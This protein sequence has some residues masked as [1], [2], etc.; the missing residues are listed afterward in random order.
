MQENQN[1]PLDGAD[2]EVEAALASLRPAAHG[3]DRDQ[4]IFTAGYRS[5][6]FK[7][8]LWRSAAGAL[9]AMVLLSIFI[10]PQL[11]ASP[12]SPGSGQLVVDTKS[13]APPPLT[14]E[15]VDNRVLEIIWA[16][17]NQPNQSP[18]SQNYLSL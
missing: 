9:A 8:W 5:A 6:R 4:L 17:G 11:P 2:R 16:L 15:R 7:L 18:R 10:R 3:I 13:Q 1:Q 14:L 12:S